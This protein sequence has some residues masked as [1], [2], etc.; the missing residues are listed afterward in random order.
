VKRLNLNGLTVEQ[1]VERFTAIALG[2]HDANEDDDIAKYTRLYREMDAVRD[3]L[4]SRDGDERRA[5]LSLLDHPNAQVRLKAAIS[6][7]A[8]APSAA[9][10]ALQKIKDRREY[11][12]AADAGACW[13]RWT[14]VPMNQAR[15]AS[16]C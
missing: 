13:T 4:K 8:V 11:P 7:L 6:L 10:A 2:Q 3:E 16:N 14:R 1:L 12:Q 9:R 15:P 5:L